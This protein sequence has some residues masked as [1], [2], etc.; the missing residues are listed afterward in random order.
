MQAYLFLI[1]YLTTRGTLLSL[2]Q[3]LAKGPELQKSLQNEI[4]NVIGTTREPALEDKQ[5]CPLVEAVTLET[6]R[7][8]SHVPVF[9]HCTAKTTEISGVPVDKNT[10][11]SISF[12]LFLCV[13]MCVI[14][15]TNS[16]EI[17]YND[18]HV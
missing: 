1:A 16:V 4:D 10:P 18:T 2:I 9:F 5:Q 17:A 8:I 15:A 12:S 13:L 14:L 6:L 11:V 7:Y 3:I